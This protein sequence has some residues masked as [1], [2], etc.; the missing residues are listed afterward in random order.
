VQAR[1]AANEREA[2]AAGRRA[3]LVEG[4]EHALSLGCGNAVARID[5]LEQR[6]GPLPADLDPDRRAAVALRVFR[7][8]AQ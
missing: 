6:L 3:E 1:D 4:H 2:D 5:N 8:I 7:E